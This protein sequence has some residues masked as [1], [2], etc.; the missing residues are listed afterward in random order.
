LFSYSLTLRTYS[1]RQSIGCTASDSISC[2]VSQARDAISTVADLAPQTAVLMDGQRVGV[3]DVSIGTLLAVKA[4]ELIPID[5]EVVSGKSSIDES[6]VTGESKPVEKMM[7]ASLWAGT[8]NLSGT[9][10]I[11]KLI[12]VPKS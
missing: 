4:G 5:G 10:W 2:V 6:N 3:E 8:M 7:G 1:I 12:F 9:T 11:Q